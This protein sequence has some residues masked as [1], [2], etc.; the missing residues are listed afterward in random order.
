[1]I[2][3]LSSRN[4]LLLRVWC[5]VDSLLSGATLVAEL[6]LLESPRRDLS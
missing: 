2:T 1:M 5:S 3:R 6:A 4:L